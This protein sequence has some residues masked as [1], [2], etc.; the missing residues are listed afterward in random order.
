MLN[1]AGKYDLK[2]KLRLI[3]DIISGWKMIAVLLSVTV[4]FGLLILWLNQNPELQGVWNSFVVDKKVQASFCEQVHLNNPVRQ[5]VNT[6]SNII[7]LVIAIVVLKTSW[8][9]RF[10]R[11][12]HDLVT[13]NTVYCF[14]FGLILLYVFFASSFY[15]TSLIN[16]AHKLDYSAVFAFSLFPIIF[17]LHRRYLN[18]NSKLLSSQKRK[19]TILFFSTYLLAN[20]LLAFLIPRGKESLAALIL[21]QIFLGLAFFAAIDKS[22]KQGRFYLALSI[23]SVL[24]A[25]IWFEIDKYKILCNPNSYFQPHSLWNLFIGISAYNFYLYIRSE[26]DSGTIGIKMKQKE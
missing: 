16:I 10:K 17:F 5:P 4:I 13:V 6:F 25:F 3:P 11:N 19:L 21:I 26:P 14:L 15:H 23:V 12:S 1:S 9:E 22:G 24:I 7:Y 20:L 2:R 8:E 18:H